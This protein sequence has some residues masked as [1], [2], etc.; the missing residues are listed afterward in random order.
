M[1]YPDVAA[2]PEIAD[3]PDVFRF[4]DGTRVER[5]EN[6]PRR[7]AEIVG[8]LLHYAYG[9]L[10][11]ANPPVVVERTSEIRAFGGTAR[12]TDA[13]LRLGP[14]QELPLH[15][16]VFAPAAGDGRFPVIMTTEAVSGNGAAPV[17]KALV[18]RGYALAGYQRHDLD[19]DNADRSD[20]AHPLYP[21]C[22]WA[23]LAVWAWGAIRVTDYL[24]TRPDIDPARIALTGHSRGGKTA[25]LA[26]ALDERIALAAPHNSGAGGAGCW[27]IEGEGSETLAVIT[28]PK[29]FRY[30]FHPRLATFAGHETRLPFDQHFLKAL[31]APRPLLCLEALDDHW[32]NPLGTQRT[33][34]AAQ[35][36]FNLL[37]AGDRIAY[38]WRPGGHEYPLQDWLAL[39]DFAGHMLL[40]KPATRDWRARP[41]GP[42]QA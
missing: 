15:V 36:V 41:F 4:A 30:W 39:A 26:A 25:L 3:L 42:P 6:W 19:A 31:I 40:G 18:E 1:H 32:A 8:M 33:N 11:A 2:L 28:D 35:P 34:E 20:G 9:H 7:R 23:T 38:W 27:R 14:R 12:R 29:R 24:L 10:P 13:I 22:D 17:A 16:T 5:A 21:E 37:G